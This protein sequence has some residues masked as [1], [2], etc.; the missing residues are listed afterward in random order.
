MAVILPR[1]EAAP[2]SAARPDRAR[3]G[4]PPLLWL[5]AGALVSL[6]LWAL[7]ARLLAGLF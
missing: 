3:R 6:G 5:L 2:R 1:S 4:P 7:I